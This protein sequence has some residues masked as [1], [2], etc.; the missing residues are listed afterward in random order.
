[1]DN[2][3]TV[4]AGLL[5]YTPDVRAETEARALDTLERL[6]RGLAGTARVDDPGDEADGIAI[7]MLRSTPC[8]SSC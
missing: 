7:A 6:K 4:H 3:E 8:V 1:V 2:L 5:D